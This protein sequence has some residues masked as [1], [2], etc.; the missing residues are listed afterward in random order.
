MAKIG[1]YIR[2][3]FANQNLDRQIVEMGKSELDMLFQDKLSGR[4]MNRPELQ[5]MLEYVKKD[6]IVILNLLSV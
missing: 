5:N 3:F 6:D 2:V 4:N 1:Y